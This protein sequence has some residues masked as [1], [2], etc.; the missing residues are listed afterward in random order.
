MST[1]YSY[2]DLIFH[3][4]WQFENPATN[5]YY[6]SGIIKGKIFFSRLGGIF[7]G[8]DAK[9]GLET[10][11][12]VFRDA[13]IEGKRY[14]R[15]T[16]YTDI[17]GGSFQSRWE[18]SQTL[19]RLNKKYNCFPEVTFICGAKTW[20][21]AVL[22][23]SQTI[24]KQN[25]VFVKTINDAFDII[26]NMESSGKEIVF[27]NMPSQKSEAVRISLT[28]IDTLVRQVGSIVWANNNTQ[29]QFFPADHPLRILQDALLELNSDFHNM[30]LMTKEQ[31]EKL[32]E[33][34]TSLR[35]QSDRLSDVIRG[36]NIGTFEWDILT[37]NIIFNDR[38]AEMLG[39]STE[40]LKPH[41]DTWNELTHPDDNAV[42][43]TQLQKHFNGELDFFDCETRMRHADGHWLWLHV[44]GKV[45]E[46]TKDNKP[47]K[48]YGTHSDI[49]LR[50]NSELLLKE[51]ENKYRSFFEDNSAVILLIEPTTGTFASVNKAA[52]RY[53]G[54][55]EQEFSKK[56][57]FDI[58][59]LPQEKLQIELSDS[60][61]HNKNH[62]VYQHRRA[63]GSIRDVEIYSTPMI[64]NNKTLL[65]SI[66][67][68]ITERIRA[69]NAE[70]K[71]AVLLSGL[72]NSIPDLVFFK[73]TFGFYMG[74]NLE[75]SKFTGMHIN[76]IV[77]KTDFDFFPDT[78]A[79]QFRQQDKLILKTGE[80]Q[81]NE[82][83]LTYANGK[84]ILVDTVKAPLQSGDKIVGLVVVARDITQ[85]KEME[86]ALRES[87]ENFQ[88]FFDTV[89]DMIFV[90]NADGNLLFANAS[91]I[92]ILGLDSSNLNSIHMINLHPEDLREQAKEIY[93]SILKN[94][95]QFSPIPLKTQNGELLAV[96]TKIWRG[97]W[98]G[99]N[100]IFG[101]SKDLSKLNAA[102]DKF[103]K[104][105]DNNPA[106]MTLLSL[107]DKKI[108]D[109]NKA[110]TEKLGFTRAELIGKTSDSL[111]ITLSPLNDDDIIE[112]L[113]KYDVI[114]NVNLQIT[115]KTGIVIDGLFSGEL[116]EHQGQVSLLQVIVDITEQRRLQ[117][118]LNRI[119][120]LHKVVLDNAGVGIAF[121]KSDLILWSNTTMCEM[122][123]YNSTELEHQSVQILFKSLDSYM[124]MVTSADPVLLAGNVFTSETIVCH[125]DGTQF[126]VSIVTKAIDPAAPSQGMILIMED[127]TEYRKATEQLKIAKESAENAN[128]AKSLFLANMSHE[129]RTPM[130]GVIGM[131]NLLG[132]TFLSPEQR[133]YT[134]VIRTSAEALLSL[135]NDILD[136][137]KIEAGKLE[138]LD[139]PFD[140]Y[141]VIED[142]VEMLSVRANEKNLE[143]VCFINPDIPSSVK[144]DAGRL[145]QIVYNLVG[146]AIKFSEHGV[147]SIHTEML[148][149]TTASILIK[150]SISDKGIG[151]PQERVPG[152]F[153]PFVQVDNTTSR[154]YGGTGLGLAISKQ[155][156]ELMNGSIGV[157]TIQFVGS[158][159]WFTVRLKK[160][161]DT[162]NRWQSG[163]PKCDSC[164]IL[165]CSPIDAVR[166]MIKTLLQYHGCMIAEAEDS[167]N[168][169]IALKNSI[170][171]SPFDFIIIDKNQPDGDGEEFG[172]AIRKDPLFNSVKLVLLTKLTQL[173][174]MNELTEKGFSGYLIKPVKHHQLYSNLI[175]IKLKSTAGAIPAQK[176]D[177]TEN[178]IDSF[179]NNIKILVV[180]DNP[181]NQ[182]VIT[183]ILKK[184]G[185][186]ADTLPN[187]IECL[188]ATKETYYDLI[189]MDCQM[190]EL[191]G[192]EATKAIRTEPATQA[193]PDVIIIAMTANAMQGDR[194]KCIASGM[195][196]YLSKPIRT[197]ELKK[198]LDTWTAKIIERKRKN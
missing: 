109:A 53:Y 144:G 152:L 147:I 127:I 83:Y 134:D 16:D 142:T 185:Y 25:Y 184:I 86:T 143:L 102:L 95:R 76:E 132:E 30:T 107:P 92:N 128:N 183:S 21:K 44:R 32:L 27:E 167:G 154:K 151:I 182:L 173:N 114:H 96:E 85:R 48:M 194:D 67:F 65:F 79:E 155:L 2:Q 145:K 15:V 120:L 104:L 131:V 125:N 156:S 57:I 77:G 162:I 58:C 153:S 138:L 108:I 8:E 172:K 82:L 23:F 29:V 88:A 74:A 171:K 190:P 106:L 157:E 56:T 33:S 72:L 75:F 59:V 164:N 146:N 186:H 52:I 94:E 181:I 166:T 64:I 99:T 197:D 39:Y 40:E 123:G 70:H 98:N 3:P 9:K 187:G 160:S 105:F 73:D 112:Q 38:W 12:R 149:N 192:Y 198:A 84:K 129:I 117:E 61:N 90:A 20:A 193:N 159:F 60:V 113:I 135:I 119:S 116:I 7:E 118:D 1:K 31:N 18:Y 62:H 4:D 178:D 136:F 174:E 34:E 93:A 122:F 158:T 137:S 24:I 55:T 115:T 43:E 196:D 81:T 17:T 46:W 91:M 35:K 13:E 54:W 37:G 19:K 161:S 68:D 6:H 188:K 26:N 168:A 50:K 175:K 49:S 36:T 10:F 191:D 11:E 126:W 28:D 140:L 51:S 63:D 100:C 176:P 180:E 148:E 139:E 42:V 101:I 163:Y 177:T 71:T 45:I 169:L 66:T 165:V 141:S 14:Y 87:D 150:T 110:F 130:N 195:N 47:W 78:L 170:N 111:G 41:I 22:L 133:I 103:H 97:K 80:N 89:E 5:C 69:Q 189:F 121:V 179:I 124:D